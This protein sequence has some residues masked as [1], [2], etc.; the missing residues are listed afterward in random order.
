MADPGFERRA[1]LAITWQDLVMPVRTI[2]GYQQIIVEEGQRLGLEDVLPDLNQVLAAAGMLSDLVDR[3]LE[4]RADE[5][6]GGDGLQARLRHDLRTSLNAIIGYSEMVLEDLDGSSGAD[7]LRADLGKLLHAAR[8][9]L[10]PEA[11][12]V[13]EVEQRAV[14]V[15]QHGVDRGP[16]GQAGASLHAPMI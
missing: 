11:L 12:V 13:A 2:L 6:S 10:A 3:I 9:L 1:S 7:A 8:Q 4:T 14:H 5:K 15:E 16:V